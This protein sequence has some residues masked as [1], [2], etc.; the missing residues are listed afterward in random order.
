VRMHAQLLSYW[1][2]GDDVI[3]VKADVVVYRS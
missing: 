2:E 1:C 3:R